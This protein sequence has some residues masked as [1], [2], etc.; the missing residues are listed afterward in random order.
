MLFNAGANLILNESLFITEGG[1]LDICLMVDSDSKER[2][3]PFSLSIVS[4]S[5]T[6]GISP[7][8]FLLT[9]D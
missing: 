6:S 3:I 1:I 4:N 8:N 5:A 2:D 7:L 9:F